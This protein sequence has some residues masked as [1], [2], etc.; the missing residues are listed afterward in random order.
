MK[1]EAEERGDRESSDGKQL[2]LD[3]PLLFLSPQEISLID[4]LL[5][6]LGLFGELQLLVEDGHLRLVAKTKSYDAFKWRRH[7]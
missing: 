3:R 7:K 4:D 1:P 2:E 5:S 6:S